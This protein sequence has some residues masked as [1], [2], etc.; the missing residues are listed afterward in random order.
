ME[1]QNSGNS[2]GSDS[3]DEQEKKQRVMKGGFIPLLHKRSHQLLKVKHAGEYKYYVEGGSS[4]MRNGTFT[5]MGKKNLSKYETRKNKGTFRGYE[6][7]C[8]VLI[9]LHNHRMTSTREDLVKIGGTRSIQIFLSPVDV[10]DFPDY[11]DIVKHPMDFSTI[12]KKLHT[13]KTFDEFA[14]DIEVTTCPEVW[15]CFLTFLSSH[16]CALFDLV[17]VYVSSR[18]AQSKRLT[19]KSKYGM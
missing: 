16:C 19:K 14:K 7:A 13:Y 3:G 17:F 11:L 5:N 12:D 4:F 15:C 2:I 6:Q 8:A 18:F 10:K 1:N 9:D